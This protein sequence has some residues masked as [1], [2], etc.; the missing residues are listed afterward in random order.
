[1]SGSESPLDYVDYTTISFPSDR[2]S[3]LAIRR[4]HPDEIDVEGTGNFFRTE[5]VDHT[6]GTLVYIERLLA[7]AAF[8]AA[9][10]KPGDILREHGLTR[11]DCLDDLTEWYTA[12]GVAAGLQHT[13]QL[14]RDIE[15]QA[16]SQAKGPRR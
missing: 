15:S 3:L 11:A 2:I 6:I 4:A 12:Y 5:H 13:E 8:E 9:L 14:V 1:M 16:A 10:G 7:R